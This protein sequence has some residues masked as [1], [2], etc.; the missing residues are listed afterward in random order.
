[1][2]ELLFGLGLGF[3]LGVSAMGQYAIYLR[4]NRP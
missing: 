4:N 1:M 2:S 3:L